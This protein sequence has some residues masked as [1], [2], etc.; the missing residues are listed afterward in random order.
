[1][2][3]LSLIIN[4]FLK[5]IAWIIAIFVMVEFIKTKDGELRKIMIAY[6]AIEVFIY[7]SSSIY[8]YLEWKHIEIISRMAFSDMTVS[9]KD[10]V[11]IWLLS[12]FISQR[13]K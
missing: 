11:K 2:M 3:P 4:E 6:F 8:S 9:I 1:M 10:V 12:W 5:A 7:L 13:Q